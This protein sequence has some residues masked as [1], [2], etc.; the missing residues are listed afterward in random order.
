M[1]AMAQR[2]AAQAG[3]DKAEALLLSED[4]EGAAAAADDV[5]MGARLSTLSNCAVLRGKAI[6]APLLQRLEDEGAADPTESDFR[7]AWVMFQLALRFVPENEDAQREAEV[8][9]S[10]IAELPEEARPEVPPNHGEELDVV[11]VG[12]GA[13][14]VGT[15]LLLGGIFGLD[16]SRVLIVER[17]DVGETF[18]RWPKEMRFISPSFNSQGWTQ[19][20]DLNSV[21]YGTSPAFTLG[22]EHPSGEQYAKYLS[23]LAETNE[24]N[25]R[26]QTEVTAVTPLEDR[27]GF[28]VSICPAKGGVPTDLTARFVVWAG[29]EF[30]YPRASAE[31]LFPGSE[32]C[33]HNSAVR[34][35]KELPGDDFVVIGGYESG[36]DA[37]SNLS[38]CG[39]KCTVVSSTAHWDLQ[40]ED[41]S[42]ELAPYTTQRIRLACAGKK[43]P[44][45]L[46]P[47]RVHA[48][49]KKGKKY[50][51]RGT[52]GDPDDDAEKANDDD[53]DDAPPRGEHRAPVQAPGTEAVNGLATKP[54]SDLV[55]ETPVPPLLCAGFA[56]S[57]KLGVVKDLFEWGDPADASDDDDDEAS[58]A[59]MADDDENDDDDEKDEKKGGG[60]MEGSPLLNEFD[61][62]TKAPGLFLVGPSVRHG[63]LSFCFVYKFRQR[64]GIVADAIARGLGRENEAAREA[65]RDMNMFLDDF[66]CCKA[67]CGEAC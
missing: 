58:D 39:K 3:L 45:L 52:W 10:V 67:A 2:E 25:V 60:C 63:D 55:L 59:K 11:I 38:I 7:E 26:P 51:V 34:S 17:G 43:P 57:V 13:S 15:A 27:E 49:E 54:G 47:L 9:Q 22:A 37:A 48:V 53:D 33:L 18:R 21:A 12:A 20:F 5:L 30:Q 8:L 50:V 1:A 61:E 64:F 23:V 42:T 41:P 62:S 19:S 35:W 40:S 29:G 36:M 66:E 4:F 24:L 31:P 46:A 6:L 16:P 32:L 44:K 28:R 56:G 65:C 14:G